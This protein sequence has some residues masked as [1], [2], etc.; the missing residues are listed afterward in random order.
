MAVKFNPP[1]DDE[2]EV[3]VTFTFSIDDLLESLE[4]EDTREIRQKIRTAMDDFAG[5]ADCTWDTIQQ[6]IVAYLD[7]H[8]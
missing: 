8:A 4:W 7:D 3:Q 1:K 2:D 6:D 5:W